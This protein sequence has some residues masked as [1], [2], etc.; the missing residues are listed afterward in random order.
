[1]GVGL[2]DTGQFDIDVFDLDTSQVF[3]LNVNGSAKN[4]DV[5]IEG[6]LQ[7]IQNLNDKVNTATFE[8][9]NT[10]SR[11][12][13]PAFDDD[14]VIYE[15]GEKIFGGKI[16][17][18]EQV[19]DANTGIVSYVATCLDHTA[20]LDRYLFSGSFE[21]QTVAEIITAIVGA[22]ASDFDTTNVGGPTVIDRVVF[23]Q[24]SVRYCIKALAALIN[25]EWY[26]DADKNIYMFETQQSAAPYGL[27]DTNGNYVYRSLRRSADGSQI[28]NRVKVR[29]GDFQADE[30]S[31][32]YTVTEATKTVNLGD[33]FSNLVVTLNG[34]PQTVGAA[35]LYDFDD[36][37]DILYDFNQ[38][39]I[40][41]ETNLSVN[42]V[43]AWTGNPNKP[44]GY[45]LSDDDSIAAYGL[46]ER[47]IKDSAIV[48]NELA[49]QRAAAELLAFNENIVDAQFATYESGLTPGMSINIQSTNRNIDDTLII[50]QVVF[51]PIGP[52]KWAYQ[53]KCISARR[54]DLINV[55][56]KIL[57][58]EDSFSINTDDVAEEFFSADDSLSINDEAESDPFDPVDVEWIYGPQHPVS[59]A[60]V[61]RVPL[62]DRGATFI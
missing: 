11:T 45:V 2:F 43:V 51:K 56:Q 36:G 52:S 4:D 44:A 50:D 20:E 13:V 14:V 49:R 57:E 61:Q 31:G 22:K 42:D 3:V 5:N 19:I 16:T 54:Y 39:E 8:V 41:W 48:S 18:V 34:T 58:T 35:Y 33:R 62:F 60:D 30:T 37:Y 12:F 46:I 40:K 24:K 47:Y 55:L 9:R 10:P 23:N 28:V 6:R 29:G 59:H 21:N 38:G 26:V 32:S 53:V 15:A 7:V 27:T 25:Y 17:K 1:M